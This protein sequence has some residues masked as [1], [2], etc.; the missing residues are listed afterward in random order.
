MA[1]VMMALGDY[2]FSINTAALKSISE[3]HS[4]R[5]ADHN[6]AGAKPKPQFIGPD[7]SSLRFMG[8]IYPHF[9][10]GLEQTDK[11]KAEGD[12]GA[13]L[14][15]VDGTGRDWGYW[16]IRQLQ[17]EKQELF[18]KGVARKI[19]FTIELKEHPEGD[20]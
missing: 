14:R 2:R 19:E 8:M 18:T 7:L 13:P 12:K 9:R 17:V 20:A 1:D 5:W 3:T 16:T 15:L 6:V 4:W 10:G 11:M